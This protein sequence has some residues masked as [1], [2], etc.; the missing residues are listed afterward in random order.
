MISND[1]TADRG[2]APSTLS[3][4]HGADAGGEAGSGASASTHTC[5][6]RPATRRRGSGCGVGTEGTQASADQEPEADNKTNQ[7]SVVHGGNFEQLQSD[8]VSGGKENVI[9]E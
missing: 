8:E 4:C 6:A 7:E 3:S 2:S 9:G 5:G 1:E